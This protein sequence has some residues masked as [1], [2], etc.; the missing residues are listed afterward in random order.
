MWCL[1]VA[2][3]DILYEASIFAAP[4]V[5]SEWEMKWLAPD[6]QSGCLQGLALQVLAQRLPGAVAEK[7]LMSGQFLKI[8]TGYEASSQLSD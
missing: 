7:T 4:G 8:H 5:W 6:L 1:Q 2:A 3:C